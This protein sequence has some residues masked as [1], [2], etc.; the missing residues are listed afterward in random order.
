MPV[1]VPPPGQRE[2]MA[3]LPP[4]KGRHQLPGQQQNRVGRPPKPPGEKYRVVSITLPPDQAAWLDEREDPRGQL[5]RLAWGLKDVDLTYHQR[6]ELQ[7]RFHVLLRSI[8]QQQ[9]S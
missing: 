9:R 7:A 1:S 2:R 8:S 3:M 5:V 6:T 4:L